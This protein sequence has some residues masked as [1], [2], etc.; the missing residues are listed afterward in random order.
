MTCVHMRVV[1][2]LERKGERQDN[3]TG[4]TNIMIFKKQ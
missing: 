3:M 2:D 4:N 1:G